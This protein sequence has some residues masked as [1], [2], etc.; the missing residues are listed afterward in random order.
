ME[1]RIVSEYEFDARR[2]AAET[3]ALAGAFQWVPTPW[4]P[5]ARVFIESWVNGAPEGKRSEVFAEIAGEVER[6][7]KSVGRWGDKLR[8]A[9]MA[10]AKEWEQRGSVAPAAAPPR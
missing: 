1:R 5:Q 3:L 10:V 6:I 7:R 8:E 9:T 2:T 4:M